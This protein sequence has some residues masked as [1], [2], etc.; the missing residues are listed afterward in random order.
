MSSLLDDFAAALLKDSV[1]C[2]PGLHTWNGSDP[3]QRFAV[4]KNNVTASLID[5]LA[6]TYPVTLA[7]VGEDL[8]REM[9]RL[10]VRASPP[11]SPV[12]ALYGDTFPAFI[13]GFT[14]ASSLP[15][16]ADLARLEMLYVQ[17]YYAAEATSV[18]ASEI[19]GLLADERRLA[20]T[21]LTL[22]P[23]VAVSS[24][25]YAAVSLW[26]AHQHRAPTGSLSRINLEQAEAAM[27]MRR[28]LV[29]EIFRIEEGAVTFIDNLRNGATF[30]EALNMAAP[31][32]LSAT[33]Q[34]LIRTGA[35][36]QCHI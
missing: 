31:F 28:G 30:A 36:T 1:T 2:P 26:A 3:A 33:L 29:V 24:F 19:A 13:Q 34:L 9:A 15:F 6:N 17:S 7:L 16:L 12:L 23:A 32:N 5:V 27:L 11:R 21:H 20:Q 25:R 8:F 4:H 18:V 14:P 10:F 35:I 22:H